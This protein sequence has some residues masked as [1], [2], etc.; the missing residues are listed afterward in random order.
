MKI[1]MI[2]AGYVGLVSAAGFSEFGTDVVCVDKDASRIAMLRNGELPIYEP[3][4]D[5]LV[6]RNVE[7]GR[8]RFRTDLEEAVAGAEAVFIAVG[9]PS[10]R[11]DGHADLSYVYDAARKIA[12]AIRGYTVVVTK[13]TVPVGT[14]R[15]I[16]AIIRAV[17]PAAEFDVAS[18]PE[19][20]REGSA[21]ADFMRPDRVVIGTAACARAMSC[22]NCTGRYT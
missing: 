1:A 4:L 20:L 9:T 22:A 6:A 5:D 11:G 2:G 17:N 13:S 15:E 3:G 8:L 10:R 18:N 16:E 12:A 19:F 21:I 7:A 14:G